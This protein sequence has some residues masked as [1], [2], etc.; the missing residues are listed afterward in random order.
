MGNHFSLPK[1][2]GLSRTADT[3]KSNPCL[4]GHKAHGTPWTLEFGR[5]GPFGGISSSQ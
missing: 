5:F 1:L 3:L 4:S 2:Q